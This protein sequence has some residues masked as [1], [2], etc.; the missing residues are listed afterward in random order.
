VLTVN[1]TPNPSTPNGERYQVGSS[2]DLMCQALGGYSPFS[3]S[4]NSTCTGQC[5]VFGAITSTIRRNVLHSVDAG[6]HTCSVTDYIGHTGSD[7]IQI[8]LTGT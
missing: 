7:T 1:I 3:Y 4:W 2:L 5:F 8:R 6:A